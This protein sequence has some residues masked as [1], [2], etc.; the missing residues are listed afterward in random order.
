MFDQLPHLL[1]TAAPDQLISGDWI[2]KLVAA[3]GAASALVIGKIWGRR[4]AEGVIV[5]DPVPEVPT[6]K[7][8]TPPSWDAHTA[9][10]DRMTRQEVISNEL[11]HD[12]GE[13]RKD[14][15]QQYR[16]LMHAGHER[17]TNITDKLDGM[18]RGIHA[19]IDE[20]IKPKT[21][22]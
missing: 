21:S 12:L 2:L 15:A 10:C 18:A 13:V 9:L 20:L 5:R 3:V 22:R 7:V 4:E 19:R 8:S 14:M 17:E 16:E 1:A 11:R 6:R